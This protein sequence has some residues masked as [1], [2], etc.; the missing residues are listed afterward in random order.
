MS[1][2]YMEQILSVTFEREMKVPGSRPGEGDKVRYIS[3]TDPVTLPELFHDTVNRVKPS[4]VQA[5]GVI[6]E[7]TRLKL[8][9]GEQF[10]AVV[11]HGDEGWQAQIEQGAKLLGRNTAKVLGT[12][13]ITSDGRLSPCQSA[14]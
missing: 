14:K 2:T 11:L 13:I 3:F 6:R 8:S 10:F 7:G 12:D 5:A 4:L 1:R 9:D